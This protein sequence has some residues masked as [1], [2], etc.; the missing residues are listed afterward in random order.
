[1]TDHE[2]IDASSIW[3]ALDPNEVTRGR[4]EGLYDVAKYVLDEYSYESRINGAPATLSEEYI[5]TDVG[6]ATCFARVYERPDGRTGIV[7]GTTKERIVTTTNPNALF[8]DDLP[9]GKSLRADS[10]TLEET[11]IDEP[12]HVELAAKIIETIAEKSSS[13]VEVRKAELEQQRQASLK[14]R[15]HEKA[16]QKEQW[17][18]KFKD[19]KTTLDRHAEIVVI[20][21]VVGILGAMGTGVVVV[22]ML[23]D[24][25]R[26]EDVTPTPSIEA[27]PG[28][29]ENGETG[30]PLFASDLLEDEVFKGTDSDVPN[31]AM[32]YDDELNFT[33]LYKEIVIYDDEAP[34]N[35]EDFEV[36]APE[37]SSL[38]VWTDFRNPAELTVS[39]N[40]GTGEVCWIGEER[41]K[42][43]SPR[44][45]LKVQNDTATPPSED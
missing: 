45:V 13:Q 12:E 8:F 26:F 16:L 30:S 3:P 11:R 40:D 25:T 39:Y 35:C 43:D 27:A 31:L 36:I 7:F 32:G 18:R 17:K 4:V 5:A 41:D 28:V 44:I 10:V 24:D 20:G 33:D 1:M 15:A 14:A 21:T 2:R 42:Y 29:I 6:E 22:E 9:G 37:G 19:V 23:D 38:N 34:D